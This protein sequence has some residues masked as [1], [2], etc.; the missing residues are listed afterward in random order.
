MPKEIDDFSVVR[1]LWYGIYEVHGI[2]EQLERTRLW[3]EAGENT[4]PNI[5]RDISGAVD[6]AGE[7]K[8]Q[9]I[10]LQIKLLTI[11]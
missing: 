7:L 1:E 8:R 11:L 3:L 9:L 2:L 5:F 4:D 10:D 6:Y